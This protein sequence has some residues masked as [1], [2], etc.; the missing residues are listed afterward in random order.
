M[1]SLLHK[2]KYD[3]KHEKRSE[4]TEVLPVKIGF[5]GRISESKSDSRGLNSSTVTDDRA[6]SYLRAASSMDFSCLELPYSVVFGRERRDISSLSVSDVSHNASGQAISGL[7]VRLMINVPPPMTL[8]RTVE[9]TR[10]GAA[11]DVVSPYEV[12]EFRYKVKS[13][14]SYGC[15]E[16]DLNVKTPAQAESILECLRQTDVDGTSVHLLLNFSDRQVLERSVKVSAFSPDTDLVPLIELRRHSNST[17]RRES[18]LVKQL[19]LCSKVAKC[20]TIHVMLSPLPSVSDEEAFEKARELLDT[21]MKVEPRLGLT[22]TAMTSSLTLARFM[23]GHVRANSRSASDT[24]SENIS[25][26]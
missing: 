16:I 1:Y 6:I 21:C 14:M 26:G 7:S 23:L 11:V 17:L 4:F 10:F 24:K 18:E 19:E 8:R 12:D 22:V 25:I 20:G 2:G 3:A 5:C 13:C 15:R 9:P